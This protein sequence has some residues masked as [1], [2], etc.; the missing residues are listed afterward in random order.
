VPAGLTDN[1][2]PVGVELIGKPYDERTVLSLAH[3]F[4]RET[5]LREPPETTPPLNE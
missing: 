2:L 3:A 5:D 4:D 1:G